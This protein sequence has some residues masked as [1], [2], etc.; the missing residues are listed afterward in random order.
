MK[1]N[2][3]IAILYLSKNF[4][5]K[6]TLEE[7][8]KVSGISPFHFHRKFVEEN[9]CTPHA[10]LENIRMQNATHIMALFP[11]AALT[12]VAFECGY[13][14]PGIFSRAFK[15]YFGVAPS[16]YKPKSEEAPKINVMKKIKPIQIQY[17]SKKIIAVQKVPL[18]ENELN[19]AFQKIIDESSSNT[20]IIGF[21]L[22]APFHTPPEQCRYFIG[23][24]S[25]SSDKEDSLLTISSGYYTSVILKGGFHH[26]KAKM[27]ALNKE[28]NKKGFVID[29]LTGFEK[30][31]IS[32]EIE[33]FSYMQCRRELFVKI[34]R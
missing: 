7:I 17:L 12:E 18:I 5:K 27:V 25:E 34:K 19:L 26:I 2:T 6:I 8:A 4:R 16:Q 14:S 21:Y 30:V 32:K 31:S 9:N 29:S 23:K 10:Y 24:E 13:S 3:E 22:D 15:K 20:T 33:P 11:N 28:I 1:Q